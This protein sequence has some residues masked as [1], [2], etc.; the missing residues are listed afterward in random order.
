MYGCVQLISLSLIDFS[1]RHCNFSVIELF[2]SRNGRKI[3]K[4]FHC[5]FLFTPKSSFLGLLW[6]AMYLSNVKHNILFLMHSL[7]WRFN[8]FL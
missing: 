7:I 6:L 3:E 2:L 4:I 5:L 1:V 8:H